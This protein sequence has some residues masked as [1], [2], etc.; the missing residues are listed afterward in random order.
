VVLFS[1]LGFIILSTISGNAPWVLGMMVGINFLFA[2]WA[3]IQQ[4]SHFSPQEASL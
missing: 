4:A 1:A 2:G 3:L